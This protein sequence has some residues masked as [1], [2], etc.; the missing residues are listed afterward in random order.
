MELAIQGRNLQVSERLREYVTK[1]AARLQRHL[2]A[3]T[4]VKVEFTEENTRSED[5]RMLAQMTVDV[6]GTIISGEQRSST[7]YAAFDLLLDAMD[8]RLQR[9]K[10]KLYRTEQMK[11][12]RETSPRFQQDK[13]TESQS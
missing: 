11:R 2:S 13:G 7:P 8:G 12:S 3:V 9:H 5:Q 10:G 1:K 4:S 6:H